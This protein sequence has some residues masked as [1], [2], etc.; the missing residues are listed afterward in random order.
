MYTHGDTGTDKRLA[1]YVMN[2]IIKNGIPGVER[3]Y[4]RKAHLHKAGKT[5]PPG[6]VEEDGVIIEHF[7]TLVA[8]DSFS[9]EQAYSQVRATV[10]NM[11]HERYGQRSRME[12]GVAELMEH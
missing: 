2:Y 9:H 11:W 12:L 10:A 5:F 4:I 7:R 8:P 1:S 6:L 3:I